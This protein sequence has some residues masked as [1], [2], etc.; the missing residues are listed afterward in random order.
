MFCTGLIVPC[1]ANSSFIGVKTKVPKKEKTADDPERHVL[2]GTFLGMVV[3]GNEYAISCKGNEG[4][5]AVVKNSGAVKVFPD[6]IETPMCGCT[7]VSH[8][9]GDGYWDDITNEW[10]EEY[11]ITVSQ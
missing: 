1:S 7:Y 8:V 4:K 11:V 3:T 6:G 9:T 10:V 2:P 5:C